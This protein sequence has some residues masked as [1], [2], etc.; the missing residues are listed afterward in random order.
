[1]RWGYEDRWDRIVQ[2]RA[3]VRDDRDAM[4]IRVRNAFDEAGAFIT[5]VHMFA[6]VQTVLTFEVDAS[7]VAALGAALSGAGIELDE[8]SAAAIR[9]ATQEGRDVEGTL[10]LVFVHGD[11]DLRHE[12]PAVPG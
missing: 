9:A 3:I 11:P 4:T 12:V 7:R 10:A 5:D 2:L 6:G 1:M 8:G